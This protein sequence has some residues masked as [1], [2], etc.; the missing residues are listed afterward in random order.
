VE[1]GC[2]L[3]GALREGKMIYGDL[4]EADTKVWTRRRVYDVRV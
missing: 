3:G 2:G 4:T 1:C